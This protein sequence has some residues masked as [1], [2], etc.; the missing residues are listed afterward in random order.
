MQGLLTASA[1]IAAA[2]HDALDIQCRDLISSADTILEM[3]RCCDGMLQNIKHIQ[4][5]PLIRGYMHPTEEFYW[6]LCGVR[7]LADTSPTLR[8]GSYFSR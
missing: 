4:V 1:C 3:T 8:M 6:Q 2:L 5:S 7:A